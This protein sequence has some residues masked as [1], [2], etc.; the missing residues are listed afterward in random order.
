MA[1]QHLLYFIVGLQRKTAVILIL[2]LSIS[3][4]LFFVTPLY[5]QSRK[6]VTAEELI[7]LT[8]QSRADFNLA[9]LYQNFQLTQAAKNK[10]ND[11]IK[12]NYF[13][14]NSP[15]GKTFSQWVKEVDYQYA[16]VGENLAMG[17][18]SS[19]AVVKAWLKSAQHR[20]N[21]LN[22]RYNQIGIYVKKGKLE[23][24]NTFVVVQYFGAPY[25]PIMILSE[26]LLFYQR[27]NRQ[28]YPVA[29]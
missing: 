1:R 18:S 27:N 19:E 16:I 21:I 15:D 3:S 4:V 7:N 6:N 26:N 17:F 25:P 13:S 22:P 24:Q 5:G 12:K 11:L 2:L 29:V 9:P 10:A 8:N 14:H 23:D 20:Q 28:N